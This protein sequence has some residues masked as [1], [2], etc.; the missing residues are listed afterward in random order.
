[1]RCDAMRCIALQC[2]S[3]RARVSTGLLRVLNKP[4]GTL[5]FK[6]AVEN[7]ILE[8]PLSRH[9]V[10]IIWIIGRNKFSIRFESCAEF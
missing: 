7:Y 6:F 2:V 8:M 5:E 10:Q 4:L 3:A 9:L 1:M